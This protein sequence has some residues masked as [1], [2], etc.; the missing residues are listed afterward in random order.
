MAKEKLG[1]YNGVD[2]EIDDR[3]K[4]G[5]YQVDGRMHLRI[6]PGFCAQTVKTLIQNQNIEVITFAW[7][8]RFQAREIFQHLVEGFDS[9]SSTKNYAVVVDRVDNGERV[10]ELKLEPAVA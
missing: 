2:I 1:S 4:N 10:R 6:D 3:V 9:F 5:C 7:D 8:V